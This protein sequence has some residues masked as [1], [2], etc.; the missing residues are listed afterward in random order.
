MEMKNNRIFLREEKR[1]NCRIFLTIPLM[2][3][4]LINDFIKRVREP[5]VLT[6]LQSLEK[7]LPA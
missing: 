5:F 4:I 3:M 6:N 1:G 2:M 7:N